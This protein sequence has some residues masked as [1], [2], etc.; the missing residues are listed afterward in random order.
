MTSRLL[1]LVYDIQRFSVHDGPGIRTTVFLKGC[2]LRCQWCANPESQRR[3]IELRYVSKLC[4]QCGRCVKRCAQRAL[5][6]SVGGL[7]IDR[8][9]CNGCSECAKAC[10]QGALRLVGAWY[11]PD[12]VLTEV[13]KDALFY[14]LS[15]GG[16]T[17]SGGEPMLQ[18]EFSAELLRC[19]KER[20][21]DT[22]VETSGYAS[23]AKV[24]DVCQYSDLVLFDVKHLDP[25]RHRELTGVSN[26]LILENLKNLTK[27]GVNVIARLPLV[28]G[29]NDDP[30]TIRGI[31]D[32]LMTLRIRE[33]HVLPYHRLGQAKY[34][35]LGR[36]YL[37]E[38]LQPP[39][40]ATIEQTRQILEETGLS[41]SVL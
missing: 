7:V 23:W 12:E 1:G 33:I 29:R 16:L 21:L 19:A 26:D 36:D 37:L 13:E 38:E 24:M 20:G 18:S 22:A 15:Q 11:S 34:A 2:P 9:R 32:L 5:T 14:R 40:L 41:V 31:G 3:E 27:S 35:Q 8:S 25:V 10:P 17:L 6:L 4:M 39:T 30:C 28:P